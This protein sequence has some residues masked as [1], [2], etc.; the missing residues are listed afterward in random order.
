MFIRT[1][2]CGPPG[3]GKTSICKK[4]IHNYFNNHDIKKENCINF[5]NRSLTP[6]FISKRVNEI[7]GVQY[8]EPY[9]LI[10]P[11]LTT[12]IGYTT[13]YV[14]LGWLGVILYY[15]FVIIYIYIYR[16][17][18]NKDNSFCVTGFSILNTLVIFNFFDNG[19]AFSALSFQLVYPIILSIIFDKKYLKKIINRFLFFF[20]ICI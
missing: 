19:F 6:D 5:I 16:L 4:Y 9:K 8:V 2:F 3:C 15:V 14:E 1:A 17:F 13:P 12:A 7:L 11:P 10:T 18:L 20:Y